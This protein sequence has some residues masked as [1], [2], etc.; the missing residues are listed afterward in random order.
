MAKVDVV[1]RVSE[2]AGEILSPMGMALVDVEYKREG[3]D[4]VLRL[5]IERLDGGVSLDDCSE[6]SRQLSDILDV[7]D[8]VAENYALEVSSPG[9]CRPLKKVA[10]YQ[11]F[12]GKLIK[13]KTF[14]V[15][16]DAAG[17]KRKTFLGTLTGVQ[18]NAITVH[19]KEGQDATIPLDKV[20]KAN[21]E[22]EF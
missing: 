7:E 10:D 11:R 6:V 12:Q 16:A 19:L 1:E 15:L 22:F 20:A 17:N 5:F 21:L 9:I 4:M 13:V 3:R 18:D 8:F 14:E 2:I